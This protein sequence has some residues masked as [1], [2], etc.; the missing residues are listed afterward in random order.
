MSHA[1][2]MRISIKSLT[3]ICCELIMLKASYWYF[4]RAEP[5][6]VVSGEN[7]QSNSLGCRGS[8]ELIG[9][10]IKKLVGCANAIFPL[11]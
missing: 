8:F 4:W 2:C 5:L 9:F 6:P 7:H 10:K 11:L 3:P 1:Y